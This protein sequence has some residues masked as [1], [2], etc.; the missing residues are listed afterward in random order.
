MEAINEDYLGKLS[1]SDLQRILA[2]NQYVLHFKIMTPETLEKQSRLFANY[3]VAIKPTD[4]PLQRTTKIR[5][6][7]E[8]IDAVA[9]TYKYSYYKVIFYIIKMY[10]TGFNSNLV[11][12]SGSLVFGGHH[13]LYHT[14]VRKYLRHVDDE[15][16]TV[17]TRRLD[18]YE[19]D[20]SD[21]TLLSYDD[22]SGELNIDDD[23]NPVSITTSSN[24]DNLSSPEIDLTQIDFFNPLYEGILSDLQRNYNELSIVDLSSHTSSGDIGSRNNPLGN[25]CYDKENDEILIVTASGISDML[26]KTWNLACGVVISNSTSDDIGR[27]CYTSIDNSEMDPRTLFYM[28]QSI[29]GKLFGPVA[30]V[31]RKLSYNNP[32]IDDTLPT[33]PNNNKGS[34]TSLNMGNKFGVNKGTSQ[35]PKSVKTTGVSD[36]DQNKIRNSVNKLV[37]SV[38]K[39]TIGNKEFQ[40]Y[41]GQVVKQSGIKA[42]DAVVNIFATEFL[43]NRF[44]EKGIGITDTSSD[45]KSGIPLLNY[46]QGKSDKRLTYGKNKPD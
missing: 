23:G 40:N 18:L 34:T 10:R 45:V 37:K 20:F 21:L 17:L 16:D 14:L 4:H 9:N 46:E 7:Q 22:E 5:S 42:A 13:L 41:V 33:G 28:V 19:Y 12:D 31:G 25:T 39:N 43:V 3:V 24:G 29:T 35:A 44:A 26:S 8:L 30:T 27:D 2:G 1:L 11:M 6:F 38:K 36:K 32:V 15:Q